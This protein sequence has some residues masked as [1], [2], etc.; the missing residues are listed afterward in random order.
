MNKFNAIGNLVADPEEF[1]NGVG[2]SFTIAI[3]S[4]EKVGDSWEDYASFIDCKTFGKSAEL[5]QEY[6]S[7][8][9]QIGITGKIK[10]ER[11]KNDDDETRS[12]IVVILDNFDGFTFINSGDQDTSGSGSKTK[13][14]S[15]K[16]G[17]KKTTRKKASKTEV[18]DEEF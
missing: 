2:C 16:K 8:G 4:K 10:Q 6:F 3:N 14:T 1:G 13:K 9:S 11:W 15:T 18:E 17:G 12:K 5:I 7:K